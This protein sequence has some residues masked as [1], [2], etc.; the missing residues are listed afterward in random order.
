[1]KFSYKWP[2]V[3]QTNLANPQAN[4]QTNIQ[5]N[6]QANQAFLNQVFL[7]KQTNQEVPATDQTLGLGITTVIFYFMMFI[8]FL[9]L[10]QGL[11][12]SQNIYNSDPK[13]ALVIAFNYVIVLCFL[14]FNFI[15][16][17]WKD[18][19]DKERTLWLHSFLAFCVLFL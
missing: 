8:V 14:L 19:G 12:A 9:A 11:F 6:V 18:S 15:F 5:T 4:I 2:T 17:S 13:R 16:P 3:S 7:N 1:M 10:L